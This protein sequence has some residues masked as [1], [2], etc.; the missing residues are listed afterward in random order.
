[1]GFFGRLLAPFLSLFGLGHRSRAVVPA[2]EPAPW[3]KAK[4]RRSHSTS[5]CCHR[6][7]TARR[8]VKR[9]MEKRSRRI[10]WGSSSILWEATWLWLRFATDG[11][12]PQN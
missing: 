2:Y 12:G 5:A 7:T 3:L 9:E 11:I 10:N 6:N 1:M 8:R 4:R